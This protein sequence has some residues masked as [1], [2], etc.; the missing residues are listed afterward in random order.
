MFLR[1]VRNAASYC[2][3]YYL[4]D[5]ADDERW[6]RMSRAGR[7]NRWRISISDALFASIA[8]TTSTRSRGGAESFCCGQPQA[9]GVQTLEIRPGVCHFVPL[10]A[11]R[12]AYPQH[13]AAGPNFLL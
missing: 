13:A 2:A 9:H 11:T 5:T 10:C 8:V 6:G 4:G 12:S 7:K 1:A 3:Y